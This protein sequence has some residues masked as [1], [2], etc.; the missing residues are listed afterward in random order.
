MVRKLA[1]IATCDDIP[2][3]CFALVVP[4]SLRAP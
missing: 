1:V 3:V 2:M 4:E